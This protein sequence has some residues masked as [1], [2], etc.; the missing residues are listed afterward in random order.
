VAG[1]RI[2]FGLVVNTPGSDLPMRVDRLTKLVGAHVGLEVTRF[3]APTY[4]ALATEVRKGQVDVA[5]LPPIVFVRLA[6]AVTPL[7][8]IMRDGKTA[9]EAALVVRSDSRIRSIEG[10]RG[11]RA[12]WV[13]PWSAAGFVLPRVKLALL[14]VD[15]RTAF[16]TETFH[17]SH[18]AAMKALAEGACDVAGTYAQSDEAGNVTAGAWSEIEGASVRVLAT[19]GAIPPDV[20]AVRNGFSDET[21][22]KVLEALKAACTEESSRK[23]LREI[24]N[25][26]DLREGLASGYESLKSALDMATA[27]GLF[28]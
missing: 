11:S 16:R 23:V 22:S 9:Y 26:D 27:R 10:L 2:V 7:G 15:P 20:I 24:F 17:G 25:G 6:D 28:D 8:S 12:G 1:P 21:R 14:G 5:W 18:R 13:D 3:D 4:E 19:F